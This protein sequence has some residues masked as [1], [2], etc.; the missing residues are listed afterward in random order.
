[1]IAGDQ[2]D[3]NWEDTEA[4]PDSQAVAGESQ[5][6][7][8]FGGNQDR[9]LAGS[10]QCRNFRACLSVEVPQPDYVCSQPSAFGRTNVMY[11]L[12]SASLSPI[13]GAFIENHMM[14][15]EMV[16]LVL[17][18]MAN[19][20]HNKESL[21]LCEFKFAVLWYKSKYTTFLWPF[22]SVL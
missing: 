20:F 9:R 1:M 21:I 6:D 5:P 15:T 4:I 22:T 3:S 17:T 10:S 13:Q 16:G 19:Y 2:E 14:G 8:S 12:H 7:E 11:G 18:S